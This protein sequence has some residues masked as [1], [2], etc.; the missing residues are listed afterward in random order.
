VFLRVLVRLP[1]LSIEVATEPFNSAPEKIFVPADTDPVK[2]QPLN[3][4]LR[5]RDLE[6]RGSS[7]VV[8][9]FVVAARFFA[10]VTIKKPPFPLKALMK[11]EGSLES[12]WPQPGRSRTRD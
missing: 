11:I 3:L 4:E 10:R 6:L 1:G 7:Y 8:A 5:G 2:F 9:V 12:V